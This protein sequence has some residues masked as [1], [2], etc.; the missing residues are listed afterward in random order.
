[1]AT[2]C[3]FLNDVKNILNISNLVVLNKRSEDTISL[4]ESFD[5]V[6]ARAVSSVKNM[7]LLTHHLLKIDGILCLP[8]GKNYIAEVEEL[9]NL[10]PNEKNNISI[11]EYKNDSNEI[12]AIVLIKKTKSTPKKWPLSWKQISNYKSKAL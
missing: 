5:I 10:F 2:R 3:D 9:L 7:F 8:K 11:H 4:S 1:M 6:T 12:S